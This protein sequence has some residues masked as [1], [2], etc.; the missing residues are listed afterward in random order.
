MR[1]SV[2]TNS[3]FVSILC[4]DKRILLLTFPRMPDA[5]SPPGRFFPGFGGGATYKAREKRPGDEVGPDGE[6]PTIL[7]QTAFNHYI[8]RVTTS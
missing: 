4:G 8:G 1:S 7:L 3:E 6:V 2:Y 5:N